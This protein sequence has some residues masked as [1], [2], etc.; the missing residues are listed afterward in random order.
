MTLLLVSST[1][2]HAW[3]RKGSAVQHGC[4][5]TWQG[6][7]F[8]IQ[9]Q[10]LQSHCVCQLEQ[11]S[12]RLGLH[13]TILMHCFSR[14][15]PVSSTKTACTAACRLSSLSQCWKKTADCCTGSNTA[16]LP[17]EGNKG[18]PLTCV[19]SSEL[20]STLQCLP[21]QLSHCF[22]GNFVLRHTTH[23]MMLSSLPA[24]QQACLC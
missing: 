4:W 23:H 5:A 22:K 24:D 10:P 17:A 2:W 8:S 18:Q 3:W 12:C 7:V 14:D 19:C 21:S 20:H 6:C 15:S 11:R 13:R 1:Q 9:Q 16:T